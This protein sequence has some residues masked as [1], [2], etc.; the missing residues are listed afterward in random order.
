MEHYAE[1]QA[2]GN[3]ISAVVMR[4]GD[5][6]APHTDGLRHQFMPQSIELADDPMLTLF[7]KRELPVSRGL[8]WEHD[9]TALRFTA[10]IPSTASGRQAREYLDAGIVAGV[11]AEIHPIVR[12]REGGLLV[13]ESALLSAVSL[14]DKP[15]FPQSRITRFGLEWD[16]G[17]G[18][19]EYQ[20]ARGITA[21]ILKG[22][23]VIT[24]LSRKRKIELVKDG[25]FRFAE[26]VILLDGD[27][28]RPIASTAAGGLA[29]A[30][31]AES[32]TFTLNTRKIVNTPLVAEFNAKLAAGLVQ[33]MSPGMVVVDS[34]VVQDAD[35]F[36]LTRIKEATV[37]EGYARVRGQAEGHAG[38]IINRGRGR[39]R[40]VF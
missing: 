10:S 23:P 15:A 3:E 13:Y 11:S 5:I 34:E 22:L 17:I 6:S 9:D 36:A 33:G 7:H 19:I 8:T 30:Q 16:P 12:R 29:V 21:T 35:G 26:N 31:T 24:S 27:Y 40:R 25:V 32:I 14:V 37:C 28:S 1:L 20:R 39:R 4:Y 2:Q 18:A 38:Q